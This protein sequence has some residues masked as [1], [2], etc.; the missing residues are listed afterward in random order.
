MVFKEHIST[1]ENPDV[2]GWKSGGQ[3]TL[4]ECKTSRSDF[5]ADQKKRPR[6]ST[7][8]G[9]GERRYYMA[10]RGVLNLSEIPQDWGLLE[11]YGGP[12]RVCIRVTRESEFHKLGVHQ[13]RNELRMLV[14]E[15]TLYQELP[16]GA[17]TPMQSKRVTEIQENLRRLQSGT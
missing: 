16:T 15:L 11:I 4:I 6:Q 9:L 17:L 2:L 8:I 7:R 12:K 5:L 3:S 1:H 10:P 14:S 13:L